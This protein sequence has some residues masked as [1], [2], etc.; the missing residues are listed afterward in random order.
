M[1][2]IALHLFLVQFTF[3]FSAFGWLQKACGSLTNL[4]K[5]RA[6]VGVDADEIGNEVGSAAAGGPSMS[7]GGGVPSNMQQNMSGQLDRT[8][9]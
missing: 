8:N 3:S 1:K 6:G 4:L 9:K 7:S 5:V 2:L